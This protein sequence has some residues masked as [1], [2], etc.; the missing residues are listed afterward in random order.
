M[1][2]KISNRFFVNLMDDASTLHGNL[3][4]DISLV[5]SWDGTGATPDWS[6]T[7][8]T[9]K[10]EQ[11]TISLTLLNGA[12]AVQANELSEAKWYYQNHSV[13]EEI[14]FSTTQSTI[15]YIDAGGTTQTVQGYLS[16]TP[17]GLFMKTTRNGMPALRIV[18]NL[19]S[20]SNLDLDTITFRGKLRMDGGGEVDFA[21]STQVRISSL[22][23]GGYLGVIS[24]ADGIADITEPDQTLTLYGHLYGGGSSGAVT[25]PFTTMWYLNDEQQGTS[26]GGTN[27]YTVSEGD[28]T[29]HGV[30]RCDF[31]VGGAQVY[32]TFV[33]IDDMQDPPYMYITNVITKVGGTTTNDANGNSAQIRKGERVDVTLWVGARDD[34]T[35]DTTWTTFKLKL[36]NSDNQVVTASYQGIPDVGADGW[37]TMTVSAGK[38]TFWLTGDTV[39]ALGKNAM[40][41]LMAQK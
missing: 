19:A 39:K 35:V 33:G 11:P 5:Q 25:V 23:K 13:N 2:A 14:V 24:F 41:I 4:S 27:S 36:Y 8:T 10:K 16:T 38:A 18:G 34:D 7:G 32:S 1:S 40:A 31:F 17:A 26:G 30:V 12:S 15:T 22:S 6:T 20:S 37:R 29:D 3:V 28:I 9:G 21:A